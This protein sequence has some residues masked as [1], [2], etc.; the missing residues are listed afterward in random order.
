MRRRHAAVAIHRNEA[1]EKEE[2]SLLQT[3][4]RKEKQFNR[5]VQLNAALRSISHELENLK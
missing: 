2:R 1:I 4:L 3:K 5:K